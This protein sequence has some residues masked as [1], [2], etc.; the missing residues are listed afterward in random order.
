MGVIKR[1]TS[2]QESSSEAQHPRSTSISVQSTPD[3][4]SKIARRGRSGRELVSSGNAEG[5]WAAFRLARSSSKCCSTRCFSRQRTVSRTSTLCNL[6]IRSLAWKALMIIFY[7]FVLFGY[8]LYLIVSFEE[9]LYDRLAM[10]TFIF[11]A[12]EMVLRIIAE[13]KYMLFDITPV[14]SNRFLISGSDTIKTC[15]IGSLLFWCDLVSTAAILY[16]VS[17]INSEHFRLKIVYIFLN[18]YGFPV[19]ILLRIIPSQHQ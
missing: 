19:S 17:W 4:G 14:G 7:T 1:G 12:V 16:H 18:Q 5:N 10:A 13:P 11:C 2:F 15:A 6:L 3:T 9:A 8:P